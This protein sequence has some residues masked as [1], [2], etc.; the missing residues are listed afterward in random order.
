MLRP[1]DGAAIRLGD[2]EVLRHVDETTREV[3]RVRRLQRRVGQTLAGAVR[4]DE[5]LQNVQ[6]F[7][8]VRRD[9]RLDDRAV[10]LRHQA[11][12][13][14]ELANLRRG[15][16]RAGVGHHED[17]VEG[18]LPLPPCRCESVASSVPSFS[19]MAFATWSF[20]RDQMSTTLL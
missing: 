6:A 4:R 19:I 16:A 11:A 12:H 13:A 9:G 5:V 15:T 18:L 14:G 3:T 8:E 7:T 17:G 10:R 20:A 2:H 1:F